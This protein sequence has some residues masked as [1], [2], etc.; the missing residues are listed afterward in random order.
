MV[1]GSYYDIWCKKQKDKGITKFWIIYTY[2][3]LLIIKK[4]IFFTHVKSKHKK[5]LF[6]IRKN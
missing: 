2:Y 6:I 3:K 4:T 5:L 1:P